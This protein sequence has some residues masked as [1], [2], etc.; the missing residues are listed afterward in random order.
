MKKILFLGSLW[1]ATAVNSVF[2]TTDCGTIS[3]I[4][5]NQDNIRAARHIARKV[6]GENIVT[7]FNQQH[8]ENEKE[9]PGDLSTSCGNNMRILNMMQSHWMNLLSDFTYVDTLNQGI[10]QILKNEPLSEEFKHGAYVSRVKE[11]LLR[12]GITLESLYKK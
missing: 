6:I 1:F 3:S 2:G 5:F 11:A 9:Y 4:E 7:S 8:A 10:I 12:G